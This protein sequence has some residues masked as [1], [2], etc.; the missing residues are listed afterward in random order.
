MQI[1]RSSA[2]T[3]LSWNKLWKSVLSIPDSNLYNQHNKPL[4]SRTIETWKQNYWIFFSLGVSNLLW[5]YRNFI[6]QHFTTWFMK[7]V[8]LRIL[9][10]TASQWGFVKFISEIQI[11]TAS[12]LFVKYTILCQSNNQRFSKLHIV[13]RRNKDEFNFVLYN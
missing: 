4:K 1:A 5:V 2:I 6:S 3:V 11:K 9:R 10:F 8:I 12:H 7:K 13:W